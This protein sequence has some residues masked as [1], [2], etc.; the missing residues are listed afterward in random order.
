[1]L[2]ADNTGS[3]LVGFLEVNHN[4]LSESSKRGLCAAA[5]AIPPHE[6]WFLSS[7]SPSSCLVTLKKACF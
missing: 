3:Y 1:M 2:L 5:Q 7:N 4:C 6:G